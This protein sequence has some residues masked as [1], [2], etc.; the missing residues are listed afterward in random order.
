MGEEGDYIPIAIHCDSCTK[1]GSDDSHFNVLL[2]VRDKVTRHCPQTYHN[3]LEEKGEPKR[4]QADALAS[5]CL[6]A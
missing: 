6:P 1:M 4:N 3:L 2:I 5:F